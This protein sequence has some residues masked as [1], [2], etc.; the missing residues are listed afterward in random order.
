MAY[1]VSTPVFTG[2]FDLL[3]H[4]ILEHRVELFEVRLAS[5]V[6]A[7]LAELD[8]MAGLELEVA[9]EFLLVASTLV[10]LKA[11]RLLPDEGD[12]DLDDELALW[13]ERDLLL[14][15]LLE[16]KTFKDV[17]GTLDRAMVAAARSAPRVAGPEERFLALVPAVLV[18]TRPTALRDAYLRATAPKPVPEVSVAHITAVKASV[19]DAISEV[20]DEVRRAGRATFR[21]LVA[22]LADRVEVVVR[23]LAVLELVKAGLVDVAQSGGSFGTIV[24]TWLGEEGEEGEEGEVASPA[25]ALHDLVGADRYD[26]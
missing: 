18:G 7:Y 23:F 26:G 13:E 14:A 22:G 25:R 16:C 11:R 9:S 4:L 8:K 3:L 1:E 5:I 6:D 24:V 17:A 21:A 12:V 15:R 19:A 10:E 2:P 20:A